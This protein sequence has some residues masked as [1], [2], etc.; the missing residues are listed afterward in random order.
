MSVK[1]PSLFCRDAPFG[2]QLAGLHIL[3]PLLAQLPSLIQI[4]RSGGVG[5]SRGHE[6]GLC[7][8]LQSPGLPCGGAIKIVCLGQP[9]A[10]A[11][12]FLEG[13]PSALG[14][15]HLHPMF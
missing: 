15:L 9:R 14:F 3:R 6:V 12:V 10:S 5:S 2:L 1:T 8:T 7:R 13:Q 11:S 4:S